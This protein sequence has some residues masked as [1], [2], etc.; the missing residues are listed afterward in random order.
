MQLKLKFKLLSGCRWLQREVRQVL[1]ELSESAASV[2]SG[3]SL[4]HL[5]LQITASVQT[6]MTDFVA[7][8]TTLN[9][10]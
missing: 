6:P 10:T 4:P 3:Y 1:S 5:E 2:S 9:C 7:P 8:P